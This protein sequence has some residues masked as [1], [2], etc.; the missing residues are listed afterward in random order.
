M[1]A[2]IKKKQ[3][4]IFDILIK[5]YEDQDREMK[6]K[7]EL[8]FPTY[9]TAIAE[10]VN[11]QRT[12][13]SFRVVLAILQH[14]TPR[15]RPKGKK[16]KNPVIKKKVGRPAKNTV[17]EMRIKLEEWNK[18][19][20]DISCETGKKTVTDK[21]AIEYIC[22]KNGSGVPQRE[23]AQISKD[24]IKTIGYWRDQTDIRIRKNKSRKLKN[25]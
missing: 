15:G 23:L 19:R 2:A 6:K 22:K 21:D 10:I 20:S 12:E 8:L 17:D 25:K 24:L 18:L 5:S 1:T 14:K 3:S 9:D 7:N 13:H 16:K 4:S 11:L